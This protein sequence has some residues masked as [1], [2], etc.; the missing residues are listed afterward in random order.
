M[1]T[2]AIAP[3]AVHQVRVHP[4]TSRRFARLRA[5][6]QGGASLRDAAAMAA[7]EIGEAPGVIMA[8]LLIWLPDAAAN[9][10]CCAAI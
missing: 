8:D 9:G 2:K 10:I 6:G 3:Y 7:R 1:I 4:L 5:V